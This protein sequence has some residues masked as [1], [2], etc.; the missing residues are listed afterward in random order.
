MKKSLIAISLC[1]VSTAF[2]QS[3]DS[4]KAQVG[5]KI[6]ISHYEEQQYQKT[7]EQVLQELIQAKK[8][9]TMDKLNELYKGGQ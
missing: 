5:E 1:L 6:N 4:T 8:D 7:R 2:A 3:S 9:G